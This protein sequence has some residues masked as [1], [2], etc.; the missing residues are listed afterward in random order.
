MST[1]PKKAKQAKKPDPF[2]AAVAELET[3]I[4]AV[5]LLPA[6][7]SALVA[8]IPGRQSAKN[9]VEIMHAGE[10][11]FVRALRRRAR[12]KARKRSA[13]IANL[14]QSR[15]VPGTRTFN[16]SLEDDGA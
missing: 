3:S 8:V 6:L 1:K 16:G 14:V 9:T 4:A 15:G 10:K 2:V 12:A 5:D 11:A 7:R 13:A